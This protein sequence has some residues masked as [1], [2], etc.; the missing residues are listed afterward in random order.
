MRWAKRL[1]RVFQIDVET[2]PTCGGSVK[3]LASIEDS[4]AIERI[5]ATCSA[6]IF[7][8]CGR[9]A[10]HYRPSEPAYLTEPQKTALRLRPRSVRR[11]P[12]PLVLWQSNAGG[13]GRPRRLIGDDRAESGELIATSGFQAGSIGEL[14]RLCILLKFGEKGVFTSYTRFA[15]SRSCPPLPAISRQA[16]DFM[17]EHATFSQPL[18]F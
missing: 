18:P 6:R 3:V 11:G 5:L 13:M 2:C 4:P 9:K 17:H 8:G 10:G 16:P 14:S 15:I 7:P 1:K 12:P